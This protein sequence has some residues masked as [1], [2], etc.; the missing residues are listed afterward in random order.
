MITSPYRY[1][2]VLDHRW[3]DAGSIG[4]FPESIPSLAETV[5]FHYSGGFLQGGSDLELRVR[6]STEAIEAIERSY[7][8][9]AIGVFDSAGEPTSNE[10]AVTL[11]PKRHFY[12][13]PLERE[14]DRRTTPNAGFETFLLQAP[15]LNLNHPKGSGI[16]ID[17]ARNEVIYWAVDG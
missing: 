2:I 1:E 10:N 13:L 15:R 16:S 9:Q 17:R 12:T 8:S 5:V 4:H 7:R 6:L 14:W 11:L 3:L